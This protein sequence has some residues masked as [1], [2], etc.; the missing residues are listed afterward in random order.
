MDPQIQP[1]PIVDPAAT[2]Q[3]DTVDCDPNEFYVQI[4]STK[5]YEDLNFALPKLLELKDDWKVALADASFANHRNIITPQYTILRLDMGYEITMIP[6]IED[7]QGNF[8]LYPF[9]TVTFPNRSFSTTAELVKLLNVSLG[10]FLTN[11]TPPGQTSRTLRKFSDICEFHYDPV[12][13][14]VSC[15][16]PRQ[17]GL[18]ERP[19]FGFMLRLSKTLQEL[20]NFPEP[21]GVAHG[22][23]QIM[24]STPYTTTDDDYWLENAWYEVN[25]KSDKILESVGPTYLESHS[26]NQ[27]QI[28]MKGLQRSFSQGDRLPLLRSIPVTGADDNNKKFWRSYE[29]RD[30]HYVHLKQNTLKE[31]NFFLLDER[32]NPINT[33]VN[34]TF[35]AEIPES[36]HMLLHFKKYI[37]YGSV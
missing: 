37:N 1:G 18:I 11:E 22:T 6:N 10:W 24:D 31:L 15:Q 32:N 3:I 5:S 36:L 7:S 29:P 13:H 12:R 23:L 33:T 16:I 35:K 30:R 21:D 28:C 4:N 19:F 34:N 17:S 20:L 26:N 2:V 8:D 27:L 14:R 9:H 25:L